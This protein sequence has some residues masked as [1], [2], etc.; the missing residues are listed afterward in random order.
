MFNAAR[1]KSRRWLLILVGI[2]EN[3]LTPVTARH[4]VVKSAGKSNTEAAWNR[5]R[6]GAKTRMSRFAY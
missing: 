4:H 3:G 5:A 6:T 1:E 2:K